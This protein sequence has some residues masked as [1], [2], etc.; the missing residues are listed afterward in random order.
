MGVI[1]QDVVRCGVR[2]KYSPVP[3]SH[4]SED[5]LRLAIHELNL[6]SNDCGCVVFEGE[7]RKLTDLVIF[8]GNLERFSMLSAA[9]E[10]ASRVIYLQ[11]T[12]SWWYGGSNLLP[13]IAGIAD[14]VSDI[15]QMRPCLAFGQSSG[16]YA[17]L[18]LGGLVPHIDVL[19]CSPQTFS[20]SDVKGDIYVSGHLSVQRTPDYLIDIADLYTSVRRSGY[21]SA[22][23]SASEYKNPYQSH[24]WLDHLHMAKLLNINSIDKFL[25]ASSNHSIVYQ[26]A[27]E[28]AYLL[29][30]LMV[31]SGKKSKHHRTIVRD[32]VAR[33]TDSNVQ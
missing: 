11:D 8:A 3:L 10:N 12:D 1:F 30:S 33:M 27:A 29:K 28:F 2:L 23:F 14:F 26:R 13:D 31:V 17:A 18:A 7:R 4:L 20:D 24:F 5:E 19:A 16:G 9:R 21:A 25:S 6:I 22:I 15:I 32:F